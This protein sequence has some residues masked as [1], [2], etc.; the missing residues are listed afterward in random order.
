MKKKVRIGWRYRI[1]TVFGLMW[2][3]CGG[4]DYALTHGRNAIYL[5]RFPEGLPAYLDTLPPWAEA[6][7]AVGIWGA[8]LGSILMILR[9]RL[10][11]PVFALALI[12]LTTHIAFQTLIEP[13]PAMTSKA[14]L[15]FFGV[16]WAVL[17][18]L[19][20]YALRCWKRILR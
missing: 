6:V 10:A 5:S 17:V 4:F 12:G 7:W 16:S 11:V 2:S 19:L 14:M 13:S 20:L 15:A 18:Y 1:V 9:L 8:I 3:A